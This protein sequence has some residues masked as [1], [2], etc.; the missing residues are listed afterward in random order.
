M[1]PTTFNMDAIEPECICARPDMVAEHANRWECGSCGSAAIR[2]GRTY[3][4]EFVVAKSMRAARTAQA[5]VGDV[6]D[7]EGDTDG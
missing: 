3:P 6:F 4:W 2:M 1:N 7:G 5:A